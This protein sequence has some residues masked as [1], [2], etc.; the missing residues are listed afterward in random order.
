MRRGSAL[1][2]GGAAAALGAY[3]LTSGQFFEVVEVEEEEDDDDGEDD[4]EM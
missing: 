2:L 1:W 4:G 3:V